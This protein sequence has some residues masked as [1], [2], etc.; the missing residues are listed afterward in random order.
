MNAL[1]KQLDPAKFQRL[2]RSTIVN[3]DR[4][5]EL[6]PHAHGD[7]AVILQDGTPLKLSRSYRPK[8]EAALGRSI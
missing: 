4:I 8:L 3:L 1:E 7:Y 6:Q 2:H 5:K